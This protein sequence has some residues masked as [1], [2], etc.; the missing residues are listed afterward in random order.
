VRVGR[1]ASAGVGPLATPNCAA[2]ESIHNP[3]CPSSFRALARALAAG[4]LPVT[5]ANSPPQ[6]PR[7]GQSS[8][9]RSSP[10][11]PIPPCALGAT[12]RS[13]STWRSDSEIRHL[14]T[15]T[16]YRRSTH[17]VSFAPHIQTAR[18]ARKPN[19][20]NTSSFSDPG[21]EVR[22]NGPSAQTTR[23]AGRCLSGQQ[24]HPHAAIQRVSGPVQPETHL[25]H[26]GWTKHGADWVYLQGSGR[27]GRIWAPR[28]H[29]GGN[30]PAARLSA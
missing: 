2:S 21:R 25:R 16:L 23:A 6:I 28:R 1:I 17:P 27:R 18:S 11:P 12:S 10:S 14:S 15:P 4:C 29:G 20:A 9:L 26:L 22:A 3:P 7:G 30:I 5:S 13:G 8:R 19:W 24:Q